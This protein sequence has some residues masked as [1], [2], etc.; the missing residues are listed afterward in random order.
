MNMLNRKNKLKKG[1][2]IPLCYDECAKIMFADPEHL[3][4]LILLLSNILQVKYEE[5]EDK[6]ELIPL[7]TPNEALGYK[8]T[9]RDIVVYINNEIRDKLIIEVNISKDYYEAIMNKSIYYMNEV[10]GKGLKQ[11]DNYDKVEP[12]FLICFNTF[13]V[14]KIHNKMF[15]YYYWMND[16]G[17]ILTDKQKILNINIEDCYT[18]WY[19]DTYKALTNI[20]E[21]DL[22][23]LSASMYTGKE[24]EFNR[25]ISEIS[26]SKDIKKVI[27]E[28]SKRMNEDEELKG[29]YYNFLEDSKR[30]DNSIIN[31]EKRK[32]KQEGIIEGLMEGESIGIAKTKHDLVLNMY[33]KD[34]PLELIKEISNLNI[35]EV[36]K[37]INS[38]KKDNNNIK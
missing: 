16:E 19:N 13:Y 31:D 25:C 8:K 3:E 36:Q 26:T 6:V 35:E 11:G 20:Y 1:E 4:P 7:N 15:D 38:S 21:K 33:N 2:K 23:L 17:N 12:T 14:D 32:S 37:I 9:E 22:L 18:S 5:I 34:L 27:E 29:R 30:L 28:V 24:E 10:S